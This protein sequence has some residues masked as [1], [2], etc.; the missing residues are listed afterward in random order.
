MVAPTQLSCR[1]GVLFRRHRELLLRGN[2][3][4]EIPQYLAAARG[5]AV[6]RGAVHV[7]ESGRAGGGEAVEDRTAVVD[8]RPGSGET[9]AGGEAEAEGVGR[10]DHVLLNE[11]WMIRSAEGED[12]AGEKSARG[13]FEEIVGL[14]SVRDVRCVDPLHFVAAQRER[15]AVGYG[16]RRAVGEIGDRHQRRDTA[17]KRRGVRRSGQKLIERVHP[18]CS[19]CHL[20]EQLVNQYRRDGW[21]RQRMVAC[22]PIVAVALR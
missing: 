21:R 17:A 10:F 20:I 5:G 8:V 11:G 15:L 9:G 7:G 2:A 6:P 19:W 12:V 16:A 4:R 22:T 18:A 3:P 13:A 14:P 1:R